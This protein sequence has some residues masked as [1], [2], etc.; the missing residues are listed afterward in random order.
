[1]TSGLS[2]V[3]TAHK[4][5]N[6]K[7]CQRWQYNS[8]CR[9]SHPQSLQGRWENEQTKTSTYFSVSPYAVC[10]CIPASVSD[11]SQ[12]GDHRPVHAL[13]ENQAHISKTK[14]HWAAA[15]GL[16]EKQCHFRNWRRMCSRPLCRKMAL[17]R[18]HGAAHC[19]T[20]QQLQTP[21]ASV[22]CLWVVTFTGNGNPVPRKKVL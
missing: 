14:T 18:E 1:M 4:V 2:G 17:A 7:S 3:V 15:G 20:R 5:I 19:K 6:A 13:V 9:I 8:R 12:Q 16:T 11:G 10:M 22:S 21:W